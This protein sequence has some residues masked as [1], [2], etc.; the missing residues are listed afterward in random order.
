[1]GTSE[2]DA[3]RSTRVTRGANLRSKGQT[4]RSLGTKMLKSFSAHI[5]VKSG[6]MYVKTRTYSYRPFLHTSS[7]TFC[8]RKCFVFVIFVCN[9]PGGDRMSQRP[10]DRAPTF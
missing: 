3:E 1:M 2:L 4:S 10:S 5:F 8:H 7:N 6:S 9:S